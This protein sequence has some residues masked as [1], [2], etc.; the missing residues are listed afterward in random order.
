MTDRAL[1]VQKILEYAGANGCGCLDSHDFW[2]FKTK[3]LKQ[4]VELGESAIRALVEGAMIARG[5][6]LPYEFVA[7]VDH[8][9]P[10]WARARDAIN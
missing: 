9:S 7:A 8:S 10:V 2:V 3:E 5:K 6:V 4:L 1:Y